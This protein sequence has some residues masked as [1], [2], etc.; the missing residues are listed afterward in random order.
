MNSKMN[1]VLLAANN[2][3]SQAYVQALKEK[4]INLE[5]IIILNPPNRKSMVLD[6]SLKSNQVCNWVKEGMHIPDFSISL[7]DTSANVADNVI[8][9]DASNVNDTNIVM[10]LEKLKPDL[11]LY[12]GFGG[13]IVCNDLLKIAPFLHFHSG[14]LPGF[15]GSTTIYYSLLEE[16]RCGVSA[17]LLDDE[18][19]TGVI[20]GRERFS[21]PPYGTELDHLYDG[22]IRAHV[23]VGVLSDWLRNGEFSFTE[24]QVQDSGEVYY[25]IHPVLKHI[26]ICKLKPDTKAY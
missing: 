19:D 22:A 2:T 16:G 9:L 5:S 24:D 20:V 14:W 23:M 12:S 21:A 15:R 1:V 3:R 18:I 11:V 10:Q 13:Q 6:S 8:E 25:V 4:N 7:H 17:I 26:A